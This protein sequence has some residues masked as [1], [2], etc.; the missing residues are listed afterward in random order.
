[1]RR[2]INMLECV[3]DPVHVRGAVR[4]RP[5]LERGHQHVHL[6]VRRLHRGGLHLL[7]HAGTALGETS[8]S[9]LLLSEWWASNNI[10]TNEIIVS[11]TSILNN[12]LYCEVYLCPT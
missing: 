6:G 8:H 11:I 3:P 12:W 2:R 4:A 7:L 5:R 9:Y 10:V 1:M